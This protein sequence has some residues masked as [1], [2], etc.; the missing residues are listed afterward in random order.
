[1]L[2]TKPRQ[3]CISEHEPGAGDIDCS[4][5]PSLLSFFSKANYSPSS[6]CVSCH[7]SL[8]MQPFPGKL[9]LPFFPQS[10]PLCVVGRVP[11]GT[12]NKGKGILGGRTG[13]CEGMG[14]GHDGIVG[15]IDSS[16]I[17]SAHLI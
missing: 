2:A 5:S 14:M 7:S 13:V 12:R 15:C 4:V 1:M 10:V 8:L 11:S 9:L 16:F 6:A 17:H 3:G